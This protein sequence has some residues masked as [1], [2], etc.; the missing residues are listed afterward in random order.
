MDQDQIMT[1]VNYLKHLAICYDNVYFKCLLRKRSETILLVDELSTLP[2]FAD[3]SLRFAWDKTSKK[4]EF[5]E[6][7]LYEMIKDDYSMLLAAYK[8]G[9]N[10]FARRGLIHFLTGPTEEMVNRSIYN[11][12][13]GDGQLFL[14]A[15]KRIVRDGV[16]ESIIISLIDIFIE[17]VE[18][19]PDL[20]PK[21][22]ETIC[23]H[24]GPFT[25][26]H[27][28]ISEA[29][30]L[31]LDAIRKTDIEK[32]IAFENSDRSFKKKA[33]FSDIQV[34]A[35]FLREYGFIGDEGCYRL[36]DRYSLSYSREHDE[37]SASMIRKKED[38]LYKVYL[39]NRWD[40]EILNGIG[41]YLALPSGKWYSNYTRMSE[42]AET[43]Q[44]NISKLSK[45]LMRSA[46]ETYCDRQIILRS[47]VE[48]EA[49][50]GFLKKEAIEVYAILPI[51]IKCCPEE[52][53]TV[54]GLMSKLEEKY[55]F[56]PPAEGIE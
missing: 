15:F 37:E 53:A 2:L 26:N 49:R 51:A 25:Q 7:I 46:F 17:M 36:D 43:C 31:C 56:T 45:V 9:C 23:F 41:R 44:N 1:I 10:S 22:L 33:K 27:G 55:G 21:I 47:L 38:L 54:L 8:A 6:T 3:S 19:S 48:R 39:R 4:M 18:D 42:E 34:M 30:I 28:A 13:Y 32:G 5:I 29:R 16:S 40:R 52:K 35:L 24:I 20:A 11:A 50:Q 12:T 14:G